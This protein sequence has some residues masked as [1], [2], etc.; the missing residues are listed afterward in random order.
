MTTLTRE[1]RWVSTSGKVNEEVVLRLL[2]KLTHSKEGPL[3]P[4]PKVTVVLDNAKYFKGWLVRLAAQWYD[5]ELLPLPAYSPNLNL[6]ERLWKFVKKEALACRCLA[7]FDDFQQAVERC[8]AEAGTVHKDELK[9]LLMLDF[10][11]FDGV[12][13][14]AP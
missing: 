1:V 12:P 8:L 14:L 2:K 11:L 6:I 9:L 13:T 4:G 7:T 10:Q 5:M 3:V